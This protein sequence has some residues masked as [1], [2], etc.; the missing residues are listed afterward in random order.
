MVS[1]D[2]RLIALDWLDHLKRDKY[3]RIQECENILIFKQTKSW[4]NQYFNHLKPNPQSLI[5]YLK[6][7]VFQKK[8]W[9]E[10]LN[11]EYGETKTYKQIAQVV[12]NDSKLKGCQ[13]IGQ[14][15]HANPIAIIVPCHRVIGSNGKLTGYAGGLYIKSQLL[16]HEGVKLDKINKSK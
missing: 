11:I 10:L 1:Q 7:T 2:D 5:M 3:P 15:I 16:T 13:A 14:A 12:F 8:V 9:Q 4:L 6:G